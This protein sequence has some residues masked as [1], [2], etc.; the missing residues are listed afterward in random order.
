[1]SLNDVTAERVSILKPEF[2][3]LYSQK[4]RELGY[5]L[6]LG[7]HDPERGFGLVA[8]IQPLPGSPDPI[9]LEL[10]SRIS[11][12]ILPKEYKGVPVFVHYFPL[13]EAQDN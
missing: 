3:M 2:F 4:I 10:L 1:M 6:S 13:L 8:R 7:R 12:E 11:Q 9:S 5:C